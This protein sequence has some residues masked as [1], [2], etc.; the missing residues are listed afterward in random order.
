[1]VSAKIGGKTYKR[2]EEYSE[3]EEIS[4]S[5]AIDRMLK[6][7]LDVE[8]SD[9]RLVPVKTDGGTE[10][11]Q[12]LESVEEKIDSRRQ[13]RRLMDMTLI[14]AVAWI[15]I[16]LSVGGLGPLLSAL[17]G[18]PLMLSLVYTFYKSGVRP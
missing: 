8:E 5:Q 10:M 4:R 12:K 9:M 17:T 15:A 1:M 7:G 18:I 13:F 2:L 16:Q 11:E 3:K 6:Q 14:I